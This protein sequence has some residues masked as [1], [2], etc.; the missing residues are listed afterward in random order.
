MQKSL[1]LKLI[2]ILVLFSCTKFDKDI[3]ASNQQLLNHLKN[4]NYILPD[5]NELNVS[6]EIQGDSISIKY[7][8][9]Q[10]EEY[11]KAFVNSHRK[12]K[13]FTREVKFN[14]GLGENAIRKNDSLILKGERGKRYV[15]KD[16]VRDFYFYED[17]LSIY[18]V[19]KTIQFEDSRTMFI[20]QKNGKEEFSF[21]GLS[22][23]T[24]TEDS[25]IFYSDNFLHQMRELT[26]IGFFRMEKGTLDTLFF[27]DTSW[28]V[29]F[30]FFQNS[31]EMYYCHSIYEDGINL[32]SSFAK[33][34]ITQK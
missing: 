21:F 32:K 31:D 4:G 17:K 25:L 13:H 30:A 6:G 14:E 10:P 18:H 5:E 1:F 19:V 24:S 20:N 8:S 23:K 29:N 27:E 12:R 2:F 3:I 34:E 15:L 26:P 22:T 16:S 28:F 9:V 33:M 11:F 7:Y